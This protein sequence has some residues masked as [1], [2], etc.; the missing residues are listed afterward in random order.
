LFDSVAFLSGGM[1]AFGF[2]RMQCGVD[3]VTYIYV[4][5]VGMVL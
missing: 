1:T 5:A 4:P 3:L 2:H